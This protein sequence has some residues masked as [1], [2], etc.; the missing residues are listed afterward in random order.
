MQP[1]ADSVAV[2]IL[3]GGQATRFPGELESDAGGIPL[4]LRVYRNVRAMGPVYISANVPFGAQITREL[5]CPIVADHKSGR[6]PLSGLVSTF[7]KVSQKRCFAVAGDAPLLDCTA[8][9][10]LLWAWENGLE[11]VV[12][13]RAGFLEPLCALYDR[14]AFLRE[15]GRVLKAGSGAVTAVVERL[16]HRRVSLSDERA[17]ANINTTTAR[18]ALLGIHL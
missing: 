6:G 18:D 8:L 3:V 16:N 17:L 14:M 15:A 9:R 4:L 7:E 5:D 13:E 10:E 1:A 12:A 2:V 11:A